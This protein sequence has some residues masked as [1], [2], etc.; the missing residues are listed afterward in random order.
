MARLTDRQRLQRAVELLA[1]VGHPEARKAL[2]ARG[3][4]TQELE[5]GYRLLRA[6]IE[7]FHAADEHAEP[8]DTVALLDAWENRWLPIVRAALEHRFPSVAKSVLLNL[9]QIR[10]PTLLISL[11]TLLDRIEALE[12][13]KLTAACQAH[14]LLTQRGLTPQV[15]AEARTHVRDTQRLPRIKPL[16]P[17]VDPRSKHLGAL[18]AWY[19]DWSQTAR[20][21]ISDPAVL[22]VL[23]F[24]KVGRPKG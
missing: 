21:A 8:P 17:P 3:L 18:W 5:E 4:S 13:S 11:P 9:R 16:A 19:L 7:T 6:A 23:G 14:A 2:Q 15:I 10:G 1:G 22:R 20:A 24:G 12:H